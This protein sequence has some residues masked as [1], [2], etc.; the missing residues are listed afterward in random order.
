MKLRKI[1]STLLAAAMAFTFVIADAVTASAVAGTNSDKVSAARIWT[2]KVDTSWFNKKK[3]KDSYDIYTAEQLAG[4]A[5]LADEGAHEDRFRGVTIN[6]MNDIVLNDTTN[7][8]NWKEKPPKNT[9]EPIGRKGEATGGYFPFAGTFNGNGHTISGMYVEKVRPKSL[10][11]RCEDAGLFTYISGAV[12]VNLKIE[13]SVVQSEN[14][15]GALSGLCE[16]SYIDGVEVNNVKLYS[17]GGQLAGGLIG[18]CGRVNMV[19]PIF[20]T[21]FMAFGLMPNPLI[22]NDGGKFIREGSFLNSCKAVNVDL[23]TT[24]GVP[25]AGALVGQMFDGG[26][27]NSLSVNCTAEPVGHYINGIT[28]GSILGTILY[29]GKCEL[30]NCYSYNFKFTDERFHRTEAS[31][32]DSVK[33]ISK[34]TLQSSSFAKKLGG[35]FKYVKNSTPVLKNINRYPVKVVLTGTKAKISWS[36]VSGAKKYKVYIKSNGKYKEVTSV[37][38]T[39]ATLKNIK[40]GKS[41]E[42]YI[43]AVDSKG[44]YLDVSGGKFTLKA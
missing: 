39:T 42:L 44:K 13:K 17:N 32:A 10:F 23:Y 4:L 38:G 22:F 20:Y 6:L 33:S 14:K 26:I 43:R 21:S 15:V 27:Y 2:G 41:Y 30:N 1:T 19:M 36:S 16:N 40:Q 9:W 28:Y 25:V 24:A 3:I 7:W 31:D 37:T 29:Q 8:E 18:E 34:S 12:I 11:A 5:K 35:G